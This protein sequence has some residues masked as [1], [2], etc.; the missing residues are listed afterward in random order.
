[1]V[2][3]ILICLPFNNYLRIL[4]LYRFDKVPTAVAGVVY[5]AKKLQEM[6]FNSPADCN[7][8]ACTTICNRKNMLNLTCYLV[9]EHG[10][11]VLSNSEQP[12]KIGQ[13][14]Y[15]INPWLMFQ[16]EL[17]GLYDLIVTGNK[18]QDC[19]KPPITL[20]SGNNIINIMSLVMKSVTFLIRQLFVYVNN[21]I[22]YLI[23]VFF[24]GEGL[25]SLNKNNTYSFLNAQTTSQFQFNN[26][27]EINQNEW[28]I[29]NSHC[30]YFGIY[31]FNI[32]KWKTIDPSE[33]K[34]WC[35]SATQK[36]NYLAGYLKHSNLLM[37][38]VEDE[39]EVSKCGSIESFT[40]NRP[41]SWNSRIHHKPIIQNTTKIEKRNYTINR[42]RKNPEYCHNFYPNE[43]QIFFCQS[44]TV[45]I[46][47]RGFKDCIILTNTFILF[48]IFYYFF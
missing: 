42:Y 47:A 20:N 7:G 36:R 21:V 32:T 41:P 6:L 4:I 33:I 35:N 23:V 28:R 43:S 39:Y 45:S 31:S 15:K 17:D 10:I 37:L 38:A 46:Y 29:R 18:L 19:T 3:S 30:F 26:K 25:F 14:L 2:K 8:E 12:A 24:S 13:P 34:T 11:V 16:L 48:I 40:K 9:D 1:L 5:D 27:G 44:S 22:F